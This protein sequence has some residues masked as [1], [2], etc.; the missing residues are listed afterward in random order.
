VA[1][2]VIDTGMDIVG[3]F[4]VEENAYVAYRGDA[5]RIVTGG[6]FRFCWVA[7]KLRVGRHAGGG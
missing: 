5:I 4:S 7:T 3:I 6:G 2:L 1:T